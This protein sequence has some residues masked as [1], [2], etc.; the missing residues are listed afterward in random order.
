M[1]QTCAVSAMGHTHGR[2][3]PL[4]SMKHKRISE[5]IEKSHVSMQAHSLMY[6]TAMEAT[7][8][9][10]AQRHARQGQACTGCSKA[11]E[12]LTGLRTG[13]V[14]FSTSWLSIPR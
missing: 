5:H 14:F 3:V 7:L 9:F 13:L 1:P 11:A 10:P 4:A 8:S 12:Q 6:S 2:N